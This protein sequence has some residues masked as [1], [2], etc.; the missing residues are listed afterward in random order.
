MQKEDPVRSM[1]APQQARSQDS[2][3]RMLDAALAILDRD[4]AA[5]LTIANVSLESGVSNG[6][7]YHRFGNRHQL[8]I[9]AQQRFLDTLKADW[10]T[11]AAPIW[12]VTEPHVLLARLVEV[13][14]RIFTDHRRTFHAFMVTG[15]DNTDLRA[16]G[17]RASTRAAQ[18]V[19]DQLTDRFG[20]SPQA[21]DT[22]YHML[23]AHALLITQFSDEEISTTPVPPE[24]RRHHLTRA[25]HAVLTT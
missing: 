18:F 1:R 2:T 5:G 20:C 25:L 4:G 11:A 8:F 21:A 9:A 14:V 17:T 16:R 6:A 13:F 12:Q 22:A 15:H 3:T 7:L 10:L 24:I 19:V 23:F